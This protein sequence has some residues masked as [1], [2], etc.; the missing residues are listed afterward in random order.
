MVGKRCPVAIRGHLEG[1]FGE[2]DRGRMG[3]VAGWTGWQM[4]V[5]ESARVRERLRAPTIPMF[6]VAMSSAAPAE[7]ERVLTS[8]WVGQGPEVAEF[9]RALAE[10]IGVPHVLTLNSGTSGLYL[11]LH[12]LKGRASNRGD[13]ARGEVIT[14]P[15]TCV[16]TNWSI[17]QCGFDI[18][19][20]DVNPATMNIDLDDVERKIT[21]RTRAIMVVHWGGYPVDLN[22]L[23]E[24][25]HASTALH[26]VAPAV[27]E[28]CAHAWGSTYRGRPI[29]AHGNTAVFSFQAVKHLTCGDGGL[30]VLSDTEYER[31]KLLRWYGVDREGRDCYRCGDRCEDDIPEFGFKLHMNDINAAIGLANLETADANVRRHRENAAFYDEA[32]AGVPSLRLTAREPDRESSCWL[33][34]ICV[35]NR[36][37]F[38]QRMF[39]AGIE[40][41]RVHERNDVHSCVSAYAVHLPQLD[42]VID[43]MICI[44]VG[45]WVTD[46][47]RERI[48]STIRAGW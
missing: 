35:D 37:G 25:Q 45:W 2:N 46:A 14:T 1:T 7:V 5:V 11:A 40:V 16:A 48:A 39:D 32:L 3:T 23:R 10:R 36:V 17:L 47:Q 29:G 28:D 33:Y 26:G 22:R 27:I 18:R 31:A 38:V 30:L 21:P 4:R 19:W 42:R 44:P 43:K 12:M 15:L 20:A 13:P 6:K 9:E 24:I 34:T 8:G 41:S